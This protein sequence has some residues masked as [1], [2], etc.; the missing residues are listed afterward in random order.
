IIIFIAGFI[1]GMW[2]G[3]NIL[4]AQ[5]GLE[6]YFGQNI[7]VI[8][9]V[10][11][12]PDFNVEG[13]IHFKLTEVMINGKKQTGQLWVSAST[14]Q[15]IKRS[16]I[17]FLNGQLSRG[18]GT[19]PSAIYRANIV[20]SVYIDKS[21]LGREI[22]DWFA[23][24]VRRFIA[25]PQ[26]SLG[27]GYLLGQKTELPE[28]LDND[29]RLL[30]LT[31]IVVASGYNLTILVRIARRLTAKI[32]RFTA[33]AISGFLVLG[34]ANLTGFSPSMSRA[35]LIAGLSLLAWYF[36]RK[37]HPIVLILFSAGVTILINPAYGW[38]DIGWLLSFTSFIGVIMLAP[39]I[40]SYFWGE[41]KPGIVRQ[42]IV[43]TL[44]AQVMTLPITLLV[45][46]HYS[47][48]SMIANPLIL[49]LIPLS[50]LFI[51]ISGLGAIFVIPILSFMLSRPAQ[52]LLDYTTW[53]IG[54]L[55]SLPQASS[56]INIKYSATISLYLLAICLI[57][58]LQRRTGYQFREY[59]IIE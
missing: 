57:I 58:F 21:D 22:R 39:L 31:H 25:E 43:E 42:V 28:K 36:G 56:D 50:M 34:F 37:F 12:D 10:S 19:I 17:V 23:M 32:S 44:S 15:E 33:L 59:N 11:E 29:L 26:A 2:R 1:L 16:D 18:F 53:V 55:S 35:S 30:G 47:I 9:K 5:R 14:K 48:L 20:K 24:K 3:S 54:K 6:S 7:S 45:F 13:D 27:I 8:G 38:G 41:N 52:W 40:N 49:P 46:G 4:L 51:F